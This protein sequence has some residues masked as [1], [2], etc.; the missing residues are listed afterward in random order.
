VG[1]HGSGQVTFGQA[2]AAVFLEGYMFSLECGSVLINRADGFSSSSHFWASVNGSLASCPN[3]SFLPLGLA[4]VCSLR[5][6]TYPVAIPQRLTDLYKFYR[7][8]W[9]NT[10]MNLSCYRTTLLHQVR[11]ASTSSA[12]TRLTSWVPAV[13]SPRVRTFI[14]LFLFPQYLTAP[15]LSTQIG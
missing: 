5:E 4:S 8:R 10:R 2:L 12:A 14:S 6:S 15:H 7:F 9:G 11:T 1:F 13:V 3:L